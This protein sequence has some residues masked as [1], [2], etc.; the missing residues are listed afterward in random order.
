MPASIRFR[1]LRRN[2]VEL[3]KSLLPKKFDPIGNYSDRQLTRSV[4]YR[5]LAHAEIEAYLEDRV[6]DIAKKAFDKWNINKTKTSLTLCSL[7]AFCG[8]EMKKPPD[9]LNSPQANQQT[10][11][12]ELL[13]MERKLNKALQHFRINVK[14]NHG[15]KEKNILSLLLPVGVDP[16]DLDPLWLTNMDSF[17]A[18]RGEAAHTSFRRI[19]VNNTPDPKSEFDTVNGLLAGIK[20]VDDLLNALELSVL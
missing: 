8:Q 17:G 13:H 1:T 15:V 20:Q 2:V 14:D 7:L 9:S 10:K 19:C 6:L 12:G 18:S 3:R 4:A 11:W 5:V 16:N